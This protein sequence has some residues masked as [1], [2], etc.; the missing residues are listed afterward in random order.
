[1][2]LQ[3]VHVLH[4]LGKLICKGRKSIHLRE[5]NISRRQLNSLPF[6]KYL[7]ALLTLV[8]RG[9]HMI[10]LIDIQVSHARGKQSIKAWV[11]PDDMARMD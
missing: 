11:L 9:Y 1:M 2:Q 6:A 8:K 3:Q 5:V 4:K 7:L 10:S